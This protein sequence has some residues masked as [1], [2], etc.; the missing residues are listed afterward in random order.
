MNPELN[1]HQVARLLTYSSRQLDDHTLTLLAKARQ[2][3]LCKQKIKSPAWAFAGHVFLRGF[4]PRVDY[5]WLFAGLILAALM[6]G[7]NFWQN[8]L[9]Q[10]NCDIDVAILTD[11]L[12]LEVFLD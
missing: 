9:D 1:P 8:D 11:E 6:V 12:P 10:Q 4:T 7:G 2:A 3:S 5:T